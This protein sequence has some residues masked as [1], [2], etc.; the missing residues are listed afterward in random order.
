MR[1]E[2]GVKLTAADCAHPEAAVANRNSPQKQCPAGSIVLLTADGLYANPVM[3]GSGAEQIGGLALAGAVH[4]RR[5]RRDA[6]R[7]DAPAWQE[8]VDDEVIGQLV[9]LAAKDPLAEATHWTAG[10][11]I[12][13]SP[14]SSAG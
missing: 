11:P 3:R 8:A 12:V 9:G 14:P 10:I 5:S 1:K 4:A 2:I 6:P 13:S 7:E